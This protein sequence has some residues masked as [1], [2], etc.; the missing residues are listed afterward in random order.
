MALGDLNA[1]PHKVLAPANRLPAQ[2]LSSP[3][4]H[5]PP[6]S[7]HLWSHSRVLEG[8]WTSGLPLPLHTF[9]LPAVLFPPGFHLKTTQLQGHFHDNGP[10]HPGHCSLLQT[11]QHVCRLPAAHHHADYGH[12]F[13]SAALRL[14]ELGPSPNP[15]QS[16]ACLEPGTL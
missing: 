6:S 4:S 11:P 1:R 5:S 3:L 15:S 12:L 2:G 8:T 10:V 13:T 14:R 9:P 16:S 7:T